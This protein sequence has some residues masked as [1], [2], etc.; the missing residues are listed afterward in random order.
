MGH[1]ITGVLGVGQITGAVVT[2]S[3][4]GAEA[5]ATTGKSHLMV[6]VVATGAAGEHLIGVEGVKM[7]VGA[8]RVS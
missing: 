6:G 5:C 1:S 8:Q 3:Q 4:F 2:L 7:L